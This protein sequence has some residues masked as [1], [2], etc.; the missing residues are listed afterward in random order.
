MTHTLFFVIREVEAKASKIHSHAEK[1]CAAILKKAHSQAL[2]II[3]KGDEAAKHLRESILQEA[4]DIA[5]K[6]RDTSLKKA[7]IDIEAVRS[8]ALKK[9]DKAVAHIVKRFSDLIGT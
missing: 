7:E 1:Q 3:T 6:A 4:A 5:S 8:T 9:K 2:D